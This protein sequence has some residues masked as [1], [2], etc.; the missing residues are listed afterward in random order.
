MKRRYGLA[1][2]AGVLGS[3][4]LTWGEA[5]AIP[6]FARK[7]QTSCSTCHVM[8]PKLNAFG[9]AF[10]LNGYQIPAPEG[11]EPYIKDKPLQ[12]EA[13]AWKQLW[14]QAIWPGTI[15]GMPPI[16]IRFI[17]HLEISQ[18]DTRPFRTNFEFPHEIEPLLGGTFGDDFGFFGQIEFKHPNAMA[19]Q[20]AF[21][22]I[23][24]PLT[25]I[26][27]PVPERAFNLWVG[28]FDLNY[29]P[30]YRNFTRVFRVHPLWGNKRLSDLKLI[31]PDTLK[32]ISAKNRFR[33][34]D[35]QPAVE[36]N[37]I[38]FKRFG[39]SFGLAQGQEE[40]FDTNNHKDLYYTVRLKLGGRALDGSLPGV[41]V[42]IVAPPTGGW[43]DNAISIEHF[44]YFGQFRVKPAPN[45][46][47]DDFSRF[48]VALNWTFQNL[49]LAVGYVFGHHDNPFAP[50]SFQ[51]VDYR[52]PFV[53]AEYMFLPWLMGTL[54]WEL[55]EVSRPSDLVAKGFTVS[56]LDQQRWLPG[57]AFLIRANV[58]VDIQGEIYS[59]HRESEARNRNK[60]HT[61]WV[62]LDFA[63]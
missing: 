60:P 57:V 61:L 58:R 56:S 20:Q 22:K 40:V 46:I 10:R 18:E 29:L 24:D 63:F 6:A 28:K 2:A 26:G 52:S 55:L 5:G 37:G 13:P 31:N 36:A 14:P 42:P 54:R 43:V 32:D 50:D 9:E 4:L 62:R 23:Q 12:L 25:N 35:F 41:E 19:L 59:V 53:K 16:A 3:V 1:V 8:F 11:D 45:R 30:S 27:L 51:G 7:Y 38:L 33:H 17:N 49:D 21:L 15:P 44:G 47:E 34:Q 39:Y 48:G